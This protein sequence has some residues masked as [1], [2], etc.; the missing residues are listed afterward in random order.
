MRVLSI[1]LIEFYLR[2][3][4]KKNEIIGAL[5]V[6]FS[7]LINADIRFYW[8][9]SCMWLSHI[10]Y[11][12]VRLLQRTLARQCYVGAVFSRQQTHVTG[13]M[14]PNLFQLFSNWAVWMF[15]KPS[16]SSRL[17]TCEKHSKSTGRTQMFSIYIICQCEN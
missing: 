6:S 10:F 12:F 4:K 9:L 13:W 15:Q 3:T 14:R 1:W 17:V 11:L 7:T 16:D 5:T 8:L 2:S